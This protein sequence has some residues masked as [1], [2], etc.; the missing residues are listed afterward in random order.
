MAKREHIR[1]VRHAADG[2][3]SLLAIFTSVTDEL[4]A[5]QD[6]IADADTLVRAERELAS[7]NNSVKA[8]VAALRQWVTD[9]ELGS[10]GG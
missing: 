1:A 6:E 5:V 7:A 10:V 9:T 3:E 2:A 4:A 8:A